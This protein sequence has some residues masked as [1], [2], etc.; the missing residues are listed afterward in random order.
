LVVSNDPAS[1]PASWQVAPSSYP[2]SSSEATSGVA[3]CTVDGTCVV[4][5]TGTF[6][7]PAG[8]SGPGFT[9]YPPFQVSCVTAAFCVSIDGSTDS[10]LEVLAG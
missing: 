3:S 2:P 1:G 9:G 6:P 8:E 7:S 10:P 5:G 4:S